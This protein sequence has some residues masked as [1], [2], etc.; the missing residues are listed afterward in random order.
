[1]TNKFEKYYQALCEVRDAYEDER[2]IDYER[3]T[4]NLKAEMLKL[5]AFLSDEGRTF[6]SI[7]QEYTDARD[8]GNELLNIS[9]AWPKDAK[10]YAEC[11]KKNGI[12][13]F[14][15]S[16]SST[17]LMELLDGFDKNGYKIAGM[18]DILTG[19]PYPAFEP[20]K[21][22]VLLEL[23]NSKKSVDHIG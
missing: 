6:A 22:A 21:P 14:T 3:A 1:M 15:L 18:T 20:S 9:D 16:D 23:K 7:A 10:D 11:L 12:T 8:A 19:A 5:G 2:D 17:A 13:R 4:K